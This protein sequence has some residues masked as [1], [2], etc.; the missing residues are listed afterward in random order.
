YDEP[1][2]GLDVLMREKFYRLL[3]ED[4]ADHPRTILLSTHLI[5]EIAKVV[6]RVYIIEAG[7][8]LLH[9]EVDH[10]RSKAY[11]ITGE[12]NAVSSFTEGKRIIYREAYGNGVIEA[13]YDAIHS[14]EKAKAAKLGVGVEGLPLQKFF[15]YMIEGG[16][17]IE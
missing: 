12:R 7:T 2:L 1:V 5:D 13:V 16:E 6:E 15:A 11:M 10:I 3:L 8:I 9:D 17:S 4:Y 14:D